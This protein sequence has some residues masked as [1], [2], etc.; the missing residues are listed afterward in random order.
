M[1]L[2]ALMASISDLFSEQEVEGIPLPPPLLR[3]RIQGT[4]DRQ[5]FLRIGQACADDLKKSLAL[6]HR[7][8]YSFRNV[9]EF[10]CG[11]ARILRWFH[12]P[13]DS[14]HLHGT[15]IDREAI[16]WCKKAIPY[17][18][19]E[20]NNPLP[21]LP[22]PPQTFDLICAISVFTHLDE[23][24]QFAWLEELQRVARPGAIL[25]LT[26]H[27]SHTQTELPREE[28]ATLREKGLLFKMGRTGRFKLDGLPDFYQGTY[29]TKHYIT[30]AW[31]KFFRIR[32]YVERGLNNHQDLVVLE[33]E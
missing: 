21:P 22:Y 8:L 32:H 27:G 13:P 26:I 1:R 20:V 14:C 2:S 9:L 11:C 18:T 24:Y 16:S 25:I 28:L 7:D 31:S 19:F 33:K 23:D 29:H 3:Y 10:G 6:V 15:D 30:A 5:A 4:V 12:N 17:A